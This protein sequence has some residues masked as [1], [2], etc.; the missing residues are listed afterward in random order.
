MDVNTLIKALDDEDNS[1]L[2]NLTHKKIEAM[3]KEILNELEINSETV[4]EFMN[5]L[6]EYRYV[7]GIDE[8]KYGAYLRWIPIIDPDNIKLNTGGILCDLKVVDSV[9]K[10]VCKSFR[11]KHYQFNLDECLIFLKMSNQ[12]KVLISALDHLSK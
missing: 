5:K 6:E 4:D 3:K 9:T 2:L 7:D 8:L 12:E 10:V 11:Q 1:E